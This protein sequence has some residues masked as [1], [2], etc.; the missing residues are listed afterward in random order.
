MKKII[1][2]I[3]TLAAVHFVAVVAAA[4]YLLASGRLSR[5]NTQRITEIL[6]PPPASQPASQPATQPV[7]TTRPLLKLEELLAKQAGRPATEQV[8]FIRNAFDE[9]MG[10]LERRLREMEDLQRTIEAARDQLARDRVTLAARQKTLDERESEAA[11]IENDAG[12]QAE[13]QLY[14]SMPPEQVKRVFLGLDDQIVAR[15]LQAMPPRTA[16]KII[17]EFESTEEMSRLGLIFD[18]IRRA[19]GDVPDGPAS[20]QPGGTP[21]APQASGN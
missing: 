16:S 7:A 2:L 18:R 11:R 6:F 8:E 19:G 5:D 15:Y 9:Q 3:L 20:A 14:T 13:L 12:F 10:Q 21:I 4:G 1:G 17:R